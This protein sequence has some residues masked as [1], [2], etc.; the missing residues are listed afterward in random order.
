VR[1]VGSP[2]SVQG[3]SYPIEQVV[4]LQGFRDRPDATKIAAAVLRL[5]T[6]S[7]GEVPWRLG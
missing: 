2:Q 4:E 6:F 7:A 3:W 5:I 1:H